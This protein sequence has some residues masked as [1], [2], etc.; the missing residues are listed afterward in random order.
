MP[1]PV[2]EQLLAAIATATGATYGRPAPEDERDMPVTIM[3]EG[4]DEAA[5]SDYN[6]TN[7]VMTVAIAK[8]A[9]ATDSD[10]ETMRSEAHA[11]HATI[12]QTMFADDTFGGLADGVD[13][14]AGGISIEAGKF[15]FAEA[16]FA[17]R[18]HTV[19]GDPFTID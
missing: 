14:S 5:E 18:Y 17:V 16:Q 10:P 11:L 12:I 7:I 19:R 1:T 2:R 4:E 6:T 13:Y 9:V 8:G 15:V 3:Q